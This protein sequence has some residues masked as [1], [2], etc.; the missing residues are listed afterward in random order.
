MVAAAGPLLDRTGGFGAS[1]V[2]FAALILGSGIAGW[3][4]GRARYVMVA[5]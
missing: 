1:A 4:A 5:G 3:G 2:L